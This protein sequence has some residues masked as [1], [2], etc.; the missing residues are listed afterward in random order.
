MLRKR[1]PKKRIRAIIKLI[2]STNTEKADEILSDFSEGMIIRFF[3]LRKPSLP[4]ACTA[5]RRFSTLLHLFYLF[6]AG[7][8]DF[9]RTLL[10]RQPVRRGLFSMGNAKTAESAV[11]HIHVQYRNIAK[12]PADFSLRRCSAYEYSGTSFPQ[13]KFARII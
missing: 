11:R 5:T 7:S 12:D 13:Q 10:S 1:R 9:I 2:F 4:Y 6:Q 8:A 3:Y